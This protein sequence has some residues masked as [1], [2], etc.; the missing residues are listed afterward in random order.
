MPRISFETALAEL[1]EMFPQFSDDF[2]ASL[3]KQQNGNM[4]NVV[5]SLLLM[6]QGGDNVA[7]IQS[8]QSA[9]DYY[10]SIE[11]EIRQIESSAGI[12]LHRSWKR[13]IPEDFLVMSWQPQESDDEIARRLQNEFDEQATRSWIQRELPNPGMASQ[14]MQMRAPLHGSDSSFETHSEPSS[15]SSTFSNL[16]NK[17][18]NFFT[19]R[20][21]YRRVSTSNTDSDQPNNASRLFVWDF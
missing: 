14:Q 4:E 8:A 17:F 5:T 19:E 1:R 15:A 21:G 3:L 13:K 16:K 2:F 6:S 9:N 10:K 7:Y 20:K 12:N 18:V 11:E